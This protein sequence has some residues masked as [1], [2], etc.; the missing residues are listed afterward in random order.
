MESKI[1]LLSLTSLFL[2]HMNILAMEELED[3]QI[4][5]VSPP[6]SSA[7]L[8][9]FMQSATSCSNVKCKTCGSCID[10]DLLIDHYNN[11]H[12]ILTQFIFVCGL[13]NQNVLPDDISKHL[14]INHY[15]EPMQK[16]KFK[17]FIIPINQAP[18][19]SH[20]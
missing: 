1:K 4:P 5:S 6:R 9:H 3:L 14:E 8:A 2:A 18:R 17:R 20:S 12:K 15:Q 16:R 19:Q 11:Q 13:C 10:S 7:A